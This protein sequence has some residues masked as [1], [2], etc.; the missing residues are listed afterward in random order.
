MLMGI[1]RVYEEADDVFADPGID[2]VDVCSPCGAHGEL[3]ERALRAG[4][5]VYCEVSR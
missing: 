1:P 5:H 2:V 4:K 3:V